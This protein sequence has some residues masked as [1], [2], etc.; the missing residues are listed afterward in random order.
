MTGLRICVDI[1]WSA[2]KLVAAPICAAAAGR[3]RTQIID[4]LP[5]CHHWANGGCAASCS[6]S[7]SGS[8]TRPVRAAR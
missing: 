7:S 5:G 8:S 4:V 2:I 1:G 3:V 6:L